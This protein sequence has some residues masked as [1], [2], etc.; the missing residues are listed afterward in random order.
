MEAQ[1]FYPSGQFYEVRNFNDDEHLVATAYL[2]MKICQGYG[3]IVNNKTYLYPNLADFLADMNRINNIG[4]LYDYFIPALTAINA[5]KSYC[6]HID[7][8]T[9]KISRNTKQ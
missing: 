8:N 3:I 4:D 7:K 2:G 1:V 9:M 6:M 5:H